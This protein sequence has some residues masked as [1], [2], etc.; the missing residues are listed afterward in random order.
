MHFFREKLNFISDFKDLKHEL[1]LPEGCSKSLKEGFTKI[2]SRTDLPNLDP[3]CHLSQLILLSLPSIS[4]C[5]QPIN[6]LLSEVPC[7]TE[8]VLQK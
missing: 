3:E 7:L 4:M 2:S 1:L 6:F 8:R 5:E